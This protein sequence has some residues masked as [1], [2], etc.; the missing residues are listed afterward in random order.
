[1]VVPVI[2]IVGSSRSGKTRFIEKL[3]PELKSREL[4][5]AYV[6]H[7]HKGF[8]LDHEDTDSERASKAGADI[9][10]L[11]SG[12]ETA[13]MVKQGS[14]LTKLIPTLIS[15]VDVV[16]AEG[17]RSE[18]IEKV[19]VFRSEIQG[20]LMCSSD[21]SLIAVISDEPLE[22]DLPRFGPDEIKRFVDFLER[23][24]VDMKEV[25]TEVEL[26]VNGSPVELK[27]FVK[28]IISNT[29]IAMLSSLRGMEDPH[30]VKLTLRKPKREDKA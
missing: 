9:V 20:S 12:E 7:C 21:P 29:L 1:M 30:E 3:I 18:R 24:M 13:T 10:V 25:M 16:V 22:V 15:K 2:A 6:K 28:T 8:E 27:G 19:E 17:F 23:R 11:S 4:K 14:T 5:V 26:E